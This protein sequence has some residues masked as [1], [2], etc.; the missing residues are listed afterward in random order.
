MAL[1]KK[2]KPELKRSVEPQLLHSYHS[3]RIDSKK[4]VGSKKSTDTNQHL[5]TARKLWL[6]QF[7]FIILTVAV[8]VCLISI[9]YLSN[10]PTVEIVGGGGN[11]IYQGSLSAVETKATQL[12]SSSI[13][14][15]NKITANT[16]KVSSALEE[17]FPMYSS[18]SISLPLIDHHPVINLTP[19]KPAI[20]LV[21]QVGSYLLNEDGQIMDQNT[22]T[23]AF[24]NFKL[25]EV[26]YPLN[27]HL[28]ISQQILTS[29]EVTFIQTV[30]YE[31]AA[32]GV[33]ISDMKIPQGT[34]ELDVY[35]T[36]KPYY[37]EF[38]LENDDPRQQA[39]SYLAAEQYLAGQGITP[40][41][42]VDVQVDGRVYYK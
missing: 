32:K 40:T 14:N 12:F 15:S 30:N 9:L 25:P 18:V 10:S 2:K 29:T 23:S 20:T 1:F 11:P 5:S 39:G 8:V 34:A 17:D 21:N 22:S 31:L 4:T 28:T 36:G 38:N 27:Q 26:V 24:N 19:A 13:L 37:V 16:S 42:Y 35:I 7:G 41:Q 33:D 6:E 3:V